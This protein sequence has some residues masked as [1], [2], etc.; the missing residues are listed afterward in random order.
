MFIYEMESYPELPCDFA[1]FGATQ[2]L[3]SELS[4]TATHAERYPNTL[5]HLQRA[6]ELAGLGIADLLDMVKREH[7][8]LRYVQP[9]DKYPVDK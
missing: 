2:W 5:D 6:C 8:T 4:E 3:A 9:V 7:I 1:L